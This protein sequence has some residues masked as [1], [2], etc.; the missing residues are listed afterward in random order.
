[1]ILKLIEN[2]TTHIYQASTSASEHLK[3]TIHIKDGI[4]EKAETMPPVPKSRDEWMFFALVAAK[5]EELTSQATSIEDWQVRDLS[6]L[7]TPREQDDMI[8]AF[9]LEVKDT[10]APVN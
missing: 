6:N 4:F 1:M 3:C 2:K 9:D 7:P 10:S 5:I 8:K